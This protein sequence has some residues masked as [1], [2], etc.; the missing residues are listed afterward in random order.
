[1]GFAEMAALFL[2][3]ACMTV[4]PPPPVA[5]QQKDVVT[6]PIARP[7]LPVV[8][9]Q[10]NEWTTANWPSAQTGVLSKPTPK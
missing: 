9:R 4:Q 10:L 5:G 2:V 6:Q 8:C 3:V 7:D 1:M